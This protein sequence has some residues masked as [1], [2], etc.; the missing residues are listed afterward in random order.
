MTSEIQKAF[1]YQNEEEKERLCYS[2]LESIYGGT[3]TEKEGVRIYFCSGKCLDNPIANK[4]E[5]EM[6]I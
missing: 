5:K 2:C 3:Y 4:R 6:E 1:F